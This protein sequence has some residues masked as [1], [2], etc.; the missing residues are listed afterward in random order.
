MSGVYDPE[1]DMETVF[2]PCACTTMSHTLAFKRFVAD[3]SK[4]PS[5]QSAIIQTI[6]FPRGLSLWRRFVEAA[7]FVLGVRRPWTRLD[8]ETYISRE[9]AEEVQ[10]FL[11]RAFPPII[12]DQQLPPHSDVN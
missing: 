12:S 3:A 4:Q 10:R 7:L 2:V 5:E 11:V 1:N 9:S 8:T 6:V